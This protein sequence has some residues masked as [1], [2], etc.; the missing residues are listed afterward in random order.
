MIAPASEEGMSV[1]EADLQQ[2]AGMIG[3]IADYYWMQPPAGEI[4]YLY[5]VRIGPSKEVVL[6]E[7]E[8]QR[9]HTAK[10]DRRSL[11]NK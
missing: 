7:D 1:R 11:K 3:E 5:T 2:Y 6:Y 9:I 4:F 10:S 8:I